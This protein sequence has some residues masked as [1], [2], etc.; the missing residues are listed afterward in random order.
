DEGKEVQKSP[1]RTLVEVAT[2]TNPKAELSDQ[3]KL[4]AHTRLYM[5]SQVDRAIDNYEPVDEVLPEP[6]ES[7]IQAFIDAML[8][9]ITPILLANGKEQ[10]EAGALLA[11]FSLDD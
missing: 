7:E 6:T 10:Y 2:R 8:L 11:N 4:E 9:T 5:Q 1:D 3:E